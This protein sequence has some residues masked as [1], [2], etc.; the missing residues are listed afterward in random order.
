MLRNAGNQLLG[1]AFDGVHSGNGTDGALSVMA[2]RNCTS[3]GKDGASP[4]LRGSAAV[5]LSNF[6][7]DDDTGAA[8]G[9][10]WGISPAQRATHDGQRLSN[11]TCDPTNFL[12]ETD[13]A[14]GDLL[15]ESHKFRTD[16][17]SQCCQ[18]CVDYEVGWALL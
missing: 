10:V 1:I 16:N 5:F 2:T 8:A 11:M 17:A 6:K 3:Q 4:C 7:P 9:R 18:A 13:F 15:P 12:Q 14:G